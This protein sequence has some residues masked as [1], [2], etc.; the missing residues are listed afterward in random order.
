MG[1][2]VVIVI[3]VSGSG[4]STVGRALAEALSVPFLDGDDLHTAANIAKMTEGKPLDDEDRLPWLASLA[5][6]IGEMAAADGGVVACSALKRKYRDALFAAAPTVRFLQL[7]LDPDD[8][9]ER[10]TARVDHFMP[11]ALVESQFCDYE[12]LQRG[13]PGIV[14]DALRDLADKVEAFEDYLASPA[15]RSPESDGAQRPAR[16]NRD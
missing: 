12:P 16:L 13:E 15:R 5:A 11:A 7:S 4:K 6:R 14:V 8:A 10:V 9:L 1:A 2:L 3:G